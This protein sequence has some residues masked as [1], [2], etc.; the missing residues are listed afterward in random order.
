M[1]RRSNYLFMRDA[2]KGYKL[3]LVLSSLDRSPVLECLSRFLYYA[4]TNCNK[5]AN[6][7][8][9]LHISIQKNVDKGDY[10]IM[11]NLLQCN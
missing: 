4:L 10:K 2:L 9:Q 11:M 8:L 3:K 5:C 6:S 7:V 1:N